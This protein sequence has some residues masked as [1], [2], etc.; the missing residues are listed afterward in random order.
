MI[1]PLNLT[2]LRA[3]LCIHCIILSNHFSRLSFLKANHT[4]SLGTQSKGF[5]K[6]TKVKYKFY[7]FSKYFLFF[8]FLFLAPFHGWSSN[9]SRLQSH[10]GETVYFLP[11]SP[12]EFVVLI[13]STTEEW[14]AELNLKPPSVFEPRTPGLG[15]QHFDHY[16]IAP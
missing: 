16:A 5:S 15:I 11:L 10:Y 4:I 3:F 1:V 2:Q 6:C 14:K 13:W 8:L 12:Q 7:F 9:V